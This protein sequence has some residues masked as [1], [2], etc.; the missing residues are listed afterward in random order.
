[1]KIAI[2]VLASTAFLVFNIYHDGKYVEI[3][4]SWKKY[5]Q[6]AAVAFIGF[7][8]FLFLKKDPGQTHSLLEHANKLVQYAP[9][10]KESVDLLKP[11]LWFGDQTRKS[12]PY[13]P[14]IAG[15]QYVRSDGQPMQQTPQQTRMM[16]SGGTAGG[17]T[18]STKRSVSETKKKFVAAQQGW[19]C[20]HCQKTLPAWFEVDHIVRLQNGGSNHVSNLC[21]LCRDCHGQ[22]TA[23]ETFD[24]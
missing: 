5:Y 13:S 11:L 23:T 22:K 24:M 19:K 7:S 3:L 14:G 21:A 1:M 10:D 18:Q 20:K 17:G 6:M 4:K 15:A 12:N 8:F 9:I 16:N 2:L